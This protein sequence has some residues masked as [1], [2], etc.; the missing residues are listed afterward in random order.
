MV[1]TGL[2]ITASASLSAC[3]KKAESN[4]GSFEVLDAEAT[5]TEDKFGPQFGNAFRAPPNSEP[6]AVEDGDLP[7]VSNMAEPEQVN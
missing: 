1:I 3:Q 5:R 2:I 6:I 4:A 7:P